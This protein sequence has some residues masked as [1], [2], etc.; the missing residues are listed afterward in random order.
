MAPRALE[1]A[2]HGREA[3]RF[4][5][6]RPVDERE[7]QRRLI[8]VRVDLPG[9]LECHGRLRQPPLLHAEPREEVV[10]VEEDGV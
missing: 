4:P 8:V 1:A 6:E 2:A 5:S 7:K 3:V 9:L 10:R